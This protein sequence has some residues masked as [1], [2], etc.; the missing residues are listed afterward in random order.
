[1]I[2]VINLSMRY[3]GKIL[4]K[5]VNLQFNPGCRYGLVGANGSGKS[6]FIKI[7]EGEIGPENGDIAL[8]NQ[9]KV[10][11]LKQDQY[12]YEDTEILS[13]VL[14]GK[15]KLWAALE[16]KNALFEHEEFTQ[17]DCEA[18]DE[19]E[20]IIVEQNGYTAPS[21]AAKLLEGLGIREVMHNKPLR[22]LSGGYKLRVLLAKLLFGKPDI[23]VLDEPTNHLDLFS[24]KWLEGY[25]SQFPGTLIV[26]S[27]DRHF[28]NTVCTHMADVDCGTIKIYKGNYDELGVKKMQD[29]EQKEAVLAKHD[30]RRQDLQGFIDRF[31]AKASKAKQA[32]SKARIVEKIEDEMDSI[33]LLPTS[34]LYPRLQFT[35]YRS[36][37]ANPLI[38]KGISK[39]YGEKKVLQD[40]SFEVERGNRLA[41]LGPNGVGKSTLLEILSGNIPA[42]K[43]EFEWGFATRIAYFPQDHA[44]EV[45]GSMNL[46]EWLGT[47]DTTQNQEQ[48]REVLAR[49]LFSGDTVKQPIRTLSGGE[50]ARLI[51]AKIILK[52][53]NVLIFDE[54]TNHLDMEA[55]EELSKALENYNETVIF[56]S[57][58]RHF[59]SQVANRVIEISEDGIKNFNTTYD[60]YVEKRDLDLLIASGSLKNRYG[61]DAANAKPK[62]ANIAHEDQKKSRNLL[63]QLKK[64]VSQAEEEFQKFEQKIKNINVEIG[65]E[66]FYKRSTREQQQNVLDQKKNLED[67]MEKAM[68]KWEG[69]CLELTT[70]EKNS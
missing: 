38:V 16:G 45:D 62:D 22:M 33:E 30:K 11:T 63:T 18:L 54:P 69:Y 19:F 65:A 44:R 55:I 39:S 66:D 1:M 7:L 32:Q 48:L 6:T 8:P 15:A 4:F 59:V 12:L 46:L 37:G 20:Q 36:S 3:G 51:L 57:H 41:L 67:L 14:M 61:N 49:V 70:L 35:P 21:E 13:I 10:G 28:L 56:V 17:E 34:R 2:S 25:L 64:K 42:D 58:N 5:N 9:M 47:V 43:G 40:V 52:K 23:L 31:G 27:H 29:R 24:I 68:E 60:E 50:T 53:A 26:S